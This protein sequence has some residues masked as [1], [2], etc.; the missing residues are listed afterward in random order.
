MNNSVC[1]DQRCEHAK[2]VER[3]GARVGEQIHGSVDIGAGTEIA[4]ILDFNGKDSRIIIGQ[5]CDIAA[6][7]TISCADSHRKCIGLSLEIERKP[8]VIG[9]HVF[10]GQ[11]S[12]ILGGCQIGARSV[13]GAG[14]VLKDAVLPPDSRVQSP[15]PIIE[16]GYYANQTPR[17]ERRLF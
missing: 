11:G 13:I 5:G 2:H 4:E 8:I 6:G 10:I 17:P 3:F 7:V 15:R 12:T 9:S 14:V 1:D 16:G